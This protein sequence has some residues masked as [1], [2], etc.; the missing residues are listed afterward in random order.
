MYSVLTNQTRRQLRLPVRS[1]LVNYSELSEFYCNVPFRSFSIKY[2]SGGSERYTIDH[3][4]FLVQSGHYLLANNFSSGSVEITS[5][6][7]VRG[8]CIDLEPEMLQ[9]VWSTNGR[10]DAPVAEESP[11]DLFAAD[12]F[13]ES[14]FAAQAT[15]VG[16]V[17]QSLDDR[18]SKDP[19]AD[20]RF[21]REFFLDL[22]ERLFHD[23]Q[24]I[25]RQ[26]Q[27]IPSVKARTRKELLR[28]LML[29]REYLL[30][31]W[32]EQV[33]IEQAAGSCGLSEYHFFR[34][35]R[36]VYGRSPRQF[37]L[38]YRMERALELLRKQDLNVSLV[39]EIT[40]FSDVHAFSKAFRKHFG[41]A[42]TRFFERK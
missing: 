4:P 17:L 40:G 2:V 3:T 25:Y 9:D 19:Y 35:F 34:L 31:H 6:Q 1:N 13:F 15:R 39:A 12:R 29:G 8:V 38:G 42:P 23:L 21:D 16:A 7:P 27:S 11:H 20:H 37:V 33:S 41:I 5:K 24:P 32:A 36:Q 14:T 10:P 22:A 18:L 30:A 26:L 28:R